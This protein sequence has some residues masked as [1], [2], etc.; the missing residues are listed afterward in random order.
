MVPWDTLNEAHEIWEER[1]Y[2]LN[3]GLGDTFNVRVDT[4]P[5]GSKM[6]ETLYIGIRQ[7]SADIG[8]NTLSILLNPFLFVGH[9]SIPVNHFLIRQNNLFQFVTISIFVFPFVS[10]LMRFNYFSSIRP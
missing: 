6:M 2:T 8:L 1:V 3:A 7:L 9:P 5:A 4:C 10:I